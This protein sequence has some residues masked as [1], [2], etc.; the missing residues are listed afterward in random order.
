MTE[1]LP[2][3]FR[4]TVLVKKNLCDTM[5]EVWGKLDDLVALV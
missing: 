1:L 4:P 3:K 5:D 2:N